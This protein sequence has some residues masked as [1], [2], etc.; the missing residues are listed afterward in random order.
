MLEVAA[1]EGDLGTFLAA[2][3]AA[4]IM[5]GLHGTGPFTVFIPTDEAF[6][7]LPR[8]GG[9]E[10][11]RGVRRSRR[12]A[13]VVE[14][15][16]VNM[17][18]D[19]DMV[20]AMDGP[21]V[22]HRRGHAAGR[23]G[24]RRDGDGRRCHG[25]ALRHPG[26]Q[27]RDPRHRRPC[28]SRRRPDAPWPTTT[29]A[30][31]AAPARRLMS[32]APS[33]RRG[34]DRGAR[35]Q[36][37]ARR[38]GRARCRRWCSS[39][40]ERVHRRDAGRD[41]PLEHRHLR[42]QPEDGARHG[43]RRGRRWRSARCFGVLARR[44]FGDR[45]R[46]ASSR[47]ACVGGVGRRPRCAR[48]RTAGAWIAAVVSAAA[49]VAAL[50]V[51]AATRRGRRQQTPDA[52]APS[53]RS[54]CPTVG[55]SSSRRAPSRRS[56]P[57]AARSGRS[58]RQSRSVEGARGRS[59]GRA[60]RGP[61]RRSRRRRDLRRRGRRHLAARDAERRLLPD[62][63][64]PPRAPGRSRRLVA[65]HHRD[66]RH[67]RSSSTFDDLLAMDHITEFVTLDAACRTRSAATWSATRCGPAC[68]LADLL[69]RAGPHPDATQI[70]GRSVDGWTAG[71]PTEVVADGNG[72]AWWRSR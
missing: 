35:R 52:R 20:M 27:R 56:A 50:V 4:G 25:R 36:R 16:I 51:P 15:H 49:G 29:D 28:S 13:R 65:A 62:R 31:A 2:T 32:R 6:E 45:A 72:R 66:G 41:R 10:P 43:H 3:E 59:R 26:V 12:A 61:R 40:A 39:V 33:R 70:V 7:R 14:H 69:D 68:P 67:A 42:R 46:R 48:R 18:E 60:R 17:N 64:P 11:G 21:V 22:H 24:R 54:A 8:R 30:P 1:A 47:S 63:H 5:D 53:S 34:R 19:A 55:G 71:F 58:L 38:A 23:D 57:S 44:S 9:D 37:A